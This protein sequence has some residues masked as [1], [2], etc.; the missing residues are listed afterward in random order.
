[1][2]SKKVR[3]VILR[4]P[5][6]KHVRSNL[7]IILKLAVKNE[8]CRLAKVKRL[9]HDRLIKSHLTPSQRKRHNHIGVKYR[10]LYHHYL[11]STLQCGGG[12]ACYSFQ[13]AK[14]DRFNPQDRP[15]DLCLVWVPWL[16]KWFCVKCFVLNRLGEMTH[17]DF[18][19]PVAREWVKEK[20]GI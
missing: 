6:M 11:E 1:M 5:R 10:T 17:K 16:E 7:R 8:L 13:E 19:D 14:K 12:A 9:Y 20:F 4:T 2:K 3:R 18:D 15:T